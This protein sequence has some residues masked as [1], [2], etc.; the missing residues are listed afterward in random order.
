[1]IKYTIYLFNSKVY[2]TTANNLSEALSNTGL[3]NRTNEIK[4]I[5]T[6][7]VRQDNKGV[8]K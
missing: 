5:D 8:K 3:T 6:Q 4:W 2:K 1:M 7:T